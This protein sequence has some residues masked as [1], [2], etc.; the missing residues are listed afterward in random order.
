MTA[1]FNYFLLSGSSCSCGL[2]VGACLGT[3]IGC[4]ASSVGRQLRSTGHNY[5]KWAS[6]FE[7][8]S[9]LYYRVLERLTVEAMLESDVVLPHQGRDQEAHLL[10]REQFADTAA[11]AGQSRLFETISFFGDVKL[12]GKDQTSLEADVVRKHTF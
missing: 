4:S 1:Q 5:F 7:Q 8:C 2:H 6:D 10:I 12:T 11:R 9:V 3:E